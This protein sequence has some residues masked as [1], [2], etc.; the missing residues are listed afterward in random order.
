M[1][2]KASASG[3]HRAPPRRRCKS[4]GFLAASPPA[5]FAG[6]GG[7]LPCPAPAVSY[8]RFPVTDFFCRLSDALQAGPAAL[9]TVTRARGS[10]PRVAGARQ[11]LGAA[12]AAAGSVGGGVTESRVLELMRATL[13]D[14]R[15][16]EFH[17]D[18]RGHPG[19]VRDGVCGG[20]ME[21]AIVRLRP[22][23]DAPLV[24][25]IASRL[26]GGKRVPLA[27]RCTE[28]APLSLD[29]SPDGAGFAETIDP[30]PL[31][32]V[33]GAGHIGRS[34]ARI[35]RPLD[36]SVA[37]QDD[38]PEWLD[39][40]AFPADCT[41]HARLT[42]A[43]AALGRWEGD[44]LGALVTR[45]FALDVEALNALAEI[46]GLRYVGLLG[47]RKRVATVLAAHR[48]AGGKTISPAVLRAPIGLEIGAET[49]EEIAVSIAAELIRV[50]RADREAATRSAA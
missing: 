24:A 27:T 39:A 12:N 37:V 44:R 15:P 43:V 42:E 22:E 2:P 18:L 23:T 6:A 36:F 28:A 46:S 13:A 32:L 1:K 47:S 34:L 41:R 11:F 49:P 33:I 17:A 16:R 10:T 38:R 25:E 29:A 21:I 40:A 31:L 3:S 5:N 30:S 48:D 9:A 45:G 19:D 20:T 35:A 50:R 4:D 7:V 14:G 8:G 26:R